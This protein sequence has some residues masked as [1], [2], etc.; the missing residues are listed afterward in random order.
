MFRLTIRDQIQLTLLYVGICCLLCVASFL[1]NFYIKQPDSITLRLLN[2]TSIIAKPF[3]G[4]FLI[5]VNLVCTHVSEC[6]VPPLIVTI[7]HA[8]N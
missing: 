6:V 4:R 2:D 7:V 3:K 8:G 5:T 1:N